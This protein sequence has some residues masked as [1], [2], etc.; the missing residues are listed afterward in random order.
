MF[1]SFDIFVHTPTSSNAEAFGLVYIESISTGCP[2]VF[3][4][5]GIAVDALTHRHDCLLVPYMDQESIFLAISELLV[6]A[7]LYETISF[8]AINTSYQFLPQNFMNSHLN[9]YSASV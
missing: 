8:N 9:L 4:R 5:S 7:S 1:E 2:S 6:D 3:T